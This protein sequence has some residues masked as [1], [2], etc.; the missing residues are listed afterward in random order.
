MD[1][2]FSD[3]H[4]KGT[5]LHRIRFGKHTFKSFVLLTLL[6]GMQKTF[7]MSN[8]TKKFLERYI[9]KVK[10]MG[11]TIDYN[12]I[13]EDQNKLLVSLKKDMYDQI[14]QHKIDGAA[15][16]IAMV[17]SIGEFVGD[18]TLIAET[19]SMRREIWEARKDRFHRHLQEEIPK[20]TK[21]PDVNI[22]GKYWSYEITGNQTRFFYSDESRLQDD[23]S[24]KISLEEIKHAVGN[25]EYK[26]ELIKRI[27]ESCKKAN[28]F[29]P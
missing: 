22:T 18:S 12:Q 2:K 26:K 8:H 10:E 21:I 4:N 5:F 17:Q 27:T 1:K 9:T 24:I 28:R 20:Q 23:M 14:K 29:K 11:E 16:D 13:K 3:F 6:L 25:H 7:G 19:E 15:N